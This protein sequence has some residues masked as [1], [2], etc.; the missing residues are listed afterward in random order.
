MGLDLK[1]MDYL[2]LDDRKRGEA[3]KQGGAQTVLSES[4]PD[5]DSSESGVDPILALLPDSDYT[6]DLS[7][8][9]PEDDLVDLGFQIAELVFSSPDPL[10][11]LKHVSQSFP[12]YAKSIS[13]RMNASDDVILALGTN[14][15]KVQGGSTM[16]WLNGRGVDPAN[17]NPYGY[18][19]TL[20]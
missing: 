10:S 7:T 5:A 17:M 8:P 15:E 1:K 3:A 14:M 19:S 18:V 11:T 12:R 16:V 20:R 13:T 4:D 6:V 9:I 2:A